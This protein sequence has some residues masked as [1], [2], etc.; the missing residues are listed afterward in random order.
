M[1]VMI[2]YLAVGNVRPSAGARCGAILRAGAW[3]RISTYC[4]AILTVHEACGPCQPSNWFKSEKSKKIPWNE[5]STPNGSDRPD[6]PIPRRIFPPVIR[7]MMK[8][9]THTKG[10]PI[11]RS[12]KS[13]IRETSPFGYIPCCLQCR[14][15][16]QRAVTEST[17]KSTWALDPRS[18]HPIGGDEGYKI[19]NLDS[20]V[21]S[22]R[23]LDEIH[24]ASK[25][26][27]DFSTRVGALL[28]Q[29]SSGY[30]APS[31]I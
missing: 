22:R 16:S 10:P 25:V 11:G 9:I 6:S 30:G 13:P 23:N 27:S 24:L 2:D 20:I 15:A 4:H 21:F 5:V 26:G 17:A 14:S 12:T 8:R 1:T 18:L 31:P 19:F 3:P 7:N 28:S 29:D